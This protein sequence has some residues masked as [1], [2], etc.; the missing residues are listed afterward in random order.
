MKKEVS[1]YYLNDEL[2]QLGIAHHLWGRILEFK[3]EYCQ[4]IETDSY[5]GKF[6]YFLYYMVEN[7][8]LFEKSSWS[9]YMNTIEKYDFIISLCLRG[10]D[11]YDE[12]KK[13]YEQRN[14]EYLS[15]DERVK[16]R[17]ILSNK[18]YYGFLVFGPKTPNFKQLVLQTLIS[19]LI[20]SNL[21][22]YIEVI[23]KCLNQLEYNED[24]NLRHLK[25]IKAD[26]KKYND[27]I[28][29]YIKM[30]EDYLDFNHLNNVEEEL[31]VYEEI[32]DS[33]TTNGK[34]YNNSKVYKI[35][36][37]SKYYYEQSLVFL[38]IK[39][40]LLKYN[41]ID[42]Y[43]LFVDFIDFYLNRCFKEI[44]LKDI[45][46]YQIKVMNDYLDNNYIVPKKDWDD[47]VKYI[48]E[49]DCNRE[50]ILEISKKLFSDLNI[51]DILE[52]L[53]KIDTNS[54]N[55]FISSIYIYNV[56]TISV[57]DIKNYNMPCSAIC[58]AVEGVVKKIFYN[59]LRESNEF[60]NY[61]I[62]NVD[63]RKREITLGKLG[64]N[65]NNGD[66]LD[67]ESTSFT[68]GVLPKI[69]SNCPDDCISRIKNIF[70]LT[71]Q[72]ELDQLLQ[73][74]E[75]LKNDYRDKCAHP[76]EWFDLESAKT[77]F[78]TIL[79]PS[80]EILVKLIYIYKKWKNID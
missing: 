76:G 5:K 63:R 12:M 14:F 50:K 39:S 23:K 46:I 58:V 8:L 24:S 29:L 69:V 28:E 31:I 18:D 22:C 7:N 47:K 45:L 42:K 73:D 54:Y 68:L 56:F 33:G 66:L 71:P 48:N 78:E 17:Y 4:S 64:C 59:G 27:I 70:N 35:R 13:D 2:P 77:C 44:G 79:K 80:S 67:E 57:S 21:D 75:N 32:I 38:K 51:N 34:N 40:F 3:R 15:E 30:E 36:A 16:L 62:E 49:L 6:L 72:F 55:S 1:Y 11:Y 61:L 10:I 60:K 9:S 19:N 74:I 20:D 37:T 65:K 53:S 43:Q 26:S 52:D 41:I 25:D